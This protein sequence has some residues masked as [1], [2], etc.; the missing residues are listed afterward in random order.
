MTH[1]TAP[2]V[3]QSILTGVEMGFAP[4]AFQGSMSRATSGGGR[5]EDGPG[6]AAPGLPRNRPAGLGLQGPQGHHAGGMQ[7]MQPA[8]ALKPG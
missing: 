4:F 1:P 8:C 2:G 5:A 3:V 7:H 6:A